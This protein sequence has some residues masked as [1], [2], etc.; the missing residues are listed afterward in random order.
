ML[1]TNHQISFENMLITM[2]FILYNTP[3]F[4]HTMV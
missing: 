1:E 3:E 4:Q 2:N